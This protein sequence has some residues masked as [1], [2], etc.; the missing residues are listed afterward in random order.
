MRTRSGP[1]PFSTRRR[2]GSGVVTSSLTTVG[3]LD[4]GSITSG[5]GSIDTGAS[6]I[7][8]TGTV[9]AG[10]VSLAD[11]AH[12]Y[13]G[14]GNDLDIVH[15]G[16][17][18]TLTN[19]TGDLT[20]IT[21]GVSAGGIILD[22]EDDTVEIKYSGVVGATFSTS[23]LDLVSGDAYSIGATS[24]L[25]ATTLGSGVVTSSLTTVAALDSGSITSGF[26]S[27]DTGAS[28][29]STTGT[30]TGGT[31]TDGTASLTSGALTGLASLALADNIHLY[32]GTG[33]DLDI[34]HTGTATTFTNATGDLTIITDGASAGGII[35]D[36]EDD[37]IELKYSGVVGATFST[38]GLDLASGDAYSIGATSVLNATTLGSGVVTSSL[39]TVGALDSGSIT[40]GFGSIDT[41]AS[42]I[43]TTGN[44][45]G[46]LFAFSGTTSTIS[47]ESGDLVVRTDGA[48]SGIILDSE[49]DTVEVQYSGVVGAT[50]STSGLDLV[51]GDAYSI[52]AT[53]VLN[54]T[55]LGSGVVT[56]SLTTVAALDSGS[57]T[58]GFGSIDTGASPISTT[59]TITGGTLTD[60][61]AS[62]TSGA[63]TGLA[64][65]A[66]ADNIHLYL[67]T[68]N[69]L[70][71]VHTGTA[72]TF[73]NATGRPHY[74]H[75]WCVG[76]RNH[77]GLGGRHH[78]A[79]VLGRRGGDIFD[80][81]PRPRQRRRLLD[82]GHVR[83][84]RD[85]AR[86]GRR[87]VPR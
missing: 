29:I 69:D 66:L 87:D 41:G 74:H 6:P 77:F 32:L 51:S 33:N 73:T 75:G 62:L 53:S 20:I 78:R 22:S 70:D 58:S 83:S 26:G 16:T 13:L 65:L 7:S 45:T 15:T 79:Q 5:F 1:R 52:G 31:L 8:T 59:G 11:N 2:L 28:P 44:I 42:T 21:D 3:A 85:D 57:I 37:T 64:S 39:T 55:T 25:N 49:D 54:A 72:T 27:I 14:T 56:S 50:F 67:G 30:I 68:G 76:R 40:S 24:V 82:R 10:T 9:T 19:A 4:S 18:A 17:A 12:L 23:G 63:L 80:E 60:G 61:T 48:G 84:Q 71:I 46:R 86:V 34:V 35:L 47:I 36:S 43:S 81:R 38:S